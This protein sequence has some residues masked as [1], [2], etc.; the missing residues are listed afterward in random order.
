VGDITLSAVLSQQLVSGSHHHK[1]FHTSCLSLF[2]IEGLLHYNV[3]SIIF[4]NES[5]NIHIVT[6]AVDETQLQLEEHLLSSI[7]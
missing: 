7:A 3:A 2:Q 6:L 1:P 5:R 4:L